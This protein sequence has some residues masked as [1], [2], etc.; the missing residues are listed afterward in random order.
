[1]IAGA[2]KRWRE[3]RAEAAKKRAALENLFK[4]FLRETEPLVPQGSK[5]PRAALYRHAW[6]RAAIL[7]I[8]YQQRT[9]QSHI[10][11]YREFEKLAGERYFEV[12]PIGPYGKAPLV[13]A[14]KTG[15]RLLEVE[16]Q[17]LFPSEGNSRRTHPLASIYI[18]TCDKGRVYVGQTVGSPESRWVQHRFAGTGPFKNGQLYVKWEVVEGEIDPAKLNE[19]ESYWIGFYCADM[20]GY[21]GNKGNDRKAYD[22]GLTERDRFNR[23][24]PHTTS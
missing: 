7:G 4:S 14:S 3:A 21:N 24:N 16:K 12:A 13:M 6:K 20:D 17:R 8:I 23:F 9:D 22:L 5:H 18:G 1:M 2:F 15:A 19:R 11:L 10:A